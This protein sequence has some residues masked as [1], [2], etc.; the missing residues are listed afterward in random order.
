MN[1]HLQAMLNDEVDGS[2]PAPDVEIPGEEDEETEVPTVPLRAPPIP[3]PEESLGKPYLVQALKDARSL[4]T[5]ERVKS[6]YKNE[7][8]H[9]LEVQIDKL[10]FANKRLKQDRDTSVSWNEKYKTK[11][12][13]VTRT[14]T[15]K[16]GELE[17]QRIYIN[18]LVEVRR[19]YKRRYEQICRDQA[20]YHE[21]VAQNQEFTRTITDLRERLLEW[22]RPEQDLDDS[23]Y[24]PGDQL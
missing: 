13:A 2:Q 23:D 12:E 20:D 22:E 8:L 17:D 16:N 15:V 21:I 6:N 1:A 7:Q 5:Q 4:F 11:L 18:D 14:L 10:E 19:R 3:S 24:N 9:D